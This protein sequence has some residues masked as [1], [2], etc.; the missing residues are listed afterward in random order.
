MGRREYDFELIK[1]V[2]GEDGY[3][4]RGNLSNTFSAL[5]VSGRLNHNGSEQ[6]IQQKIDRDEKVNKKDGFPADFQQHSEDN[7]SV[8]GRIRSSIAKRL[9]GFGC[10]IC[11]SLI[12]DTFAPVLLYLIY[13]MDYSCTDSF[14]SYL[15]LLLHILVYKMMGE[16]TKL[17]SFGV[18]TKVFVFMQER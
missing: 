16:T 2:M 18:F 3:L 6:S 12:Y 17:W 15:G 13:W 7:D 10:P 14:P 5:A 9:E 4:L 8:I 1:K 11:G